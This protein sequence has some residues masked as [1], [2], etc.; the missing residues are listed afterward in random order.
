MASSGRVAAA[1]FGNLLC[2]INGSGVSTIDSTTIAVILALFA[3]LITPCAL[4]SANNTKAN[5]PPCAIN[6]AR[7]NASLWLLFAN[8]ATA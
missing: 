1:F 3:S 4:A 8:R 7:S 6:I 2:T 5:S